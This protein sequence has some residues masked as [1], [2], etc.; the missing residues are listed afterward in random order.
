MLSLHKLM[1]FEAAARE[2]SLSAAASSLYMSQ[3]SVSQHIRELER[4]LG[5]ELFKRGRGGVTLTPKGEQL[6]VLARQLLRDAAEIERTITDVT[7]VSDGRLRLGATPGVSAYLVP[8][9]LRVFRTDYS[10]IEVALHTGTTDSVVEGVSHRLFD[11]GITEGDPSA[12]IDHITYEKLTGH[13]QYVVVGKYHPWWGRECVTLRELAQ[14]SLIT[15][16]PGSHSRIWLEN[17]FEQEGIRVDVAGAFDGLETIKQSVAHSDH[18]FTVLPRYAIRGEE[19]AEQ[20]HA[21]CV[22]GAELVRWLWLVHSRDMP[23]SP[24]AEAFVQTLRGTMP[25]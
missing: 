16:Q 7:H 23:L 18:C 8:G 12:A 22:Q 11:L 3:S 24:F 2:G 15:R 17:I 4:G 14:S 5:V 20:L 1:V 10:H 6:L 25:E 19:A 13:E 21:I 9:W